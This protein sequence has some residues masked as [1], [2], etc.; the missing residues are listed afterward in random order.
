MSRARRS[1]AGQ[2]SPEWLLQ[3]QRAEVQPVEEHLEVIQ[4]YRPNSCKRIYA[5]P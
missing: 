1:P 3:S 4:G 5:V 2:G